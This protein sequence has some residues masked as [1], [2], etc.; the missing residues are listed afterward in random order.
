MLQVIELVIAGQDGLQFFVVSVVDERIQDFADP[1][2]HALGAKVIENEAGHFLCRGH[3][4]S[5]LVFLIAP[6]EFAQEIR[7]AFKKDGLACGGLLF[8]DDGCKHRLAG[9]AAAVDVEP[10]LRLGDHP[11]RGPDGPLVV[12][13]DLVAVPAGIRIPL[14]YAGVLEKP[15]QMVLC[16]LLSEF[17]TLLEC[18]VELASIRHL[19]DRHHAGIRLSASADAGAAGAEL[20]LSLDDGYLHGVGFV[21]RVR[22]PQVGQTVLAVVPMLARPART[23][24]QTQTVLWRQDVADPVYAF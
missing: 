5:G 24:L 8:R 1:L 7:Y 4:F 13:G 22:H 19:D 17:V 23:G 6:S 12:T 11:L 9:P 16:L 3:D 20:L 2:V 18:A 10:F 15:C 21:L 14:R